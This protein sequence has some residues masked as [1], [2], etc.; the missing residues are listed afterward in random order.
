MQVICRVKAPFSLCGDREE[1]AI[2]KKLQ[3]CRDFCF[4]DGWIVST[5]G[6][7]KGGSLQRGKSR[8]RAYSRRQRGQQRLGPLIGRSGP[9]ALPDRVGRQPVCRGVCCGLD[10]AAPWALFHQTER[11]LWVLRQ[12]EEG[13]VGLARLR[14]VEC[15]FR[16]RQRSWLQGLF[17]AE[18]L[19][20]AL[21]F[22]ACL[23]AHWAFRFAFPQSARREFRV[24][25]AQ[26]EFCVCLVR[27]DFC[28]GLAR[29]EVKNFMLWAEPPARQTE[30]VQT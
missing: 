3:R 15:R 12:Q 21:G 29:R 16:R 25:L 17:N 28:I 18:I 6:Y 22:W 11:R 5:D 26:Q 10:G 24:G 1:F 7:R 14:R 8:R 2:A 9:R 23:E 19:Y 27:R 30:S 13:A 4:H 20:G